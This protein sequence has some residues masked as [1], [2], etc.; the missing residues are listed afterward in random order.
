[1]TFDNDGALPPFS[2]AKWPPWKTV[3]TTLKP[4]FYFGGVT[5]LVFPLRASLNALQHFCDLYL[6]ILPPEVGYFRAPF[7]YVLLLINDYGSMS[8]DVA[9][10]GWIAERE[11]AFFVPLQW[12]R[13]IN[14]RLVF[15]DYA[16]I[17]PFI[18]VDDD[19]AL[20][21]GRLV[22]GWPKSPAKSTPTAST[23]VGNPQGPICELTMTASLFPQFFTGQSPQTEV[24]LSVEHER[25][26]ANLRFPFNVQNPLNPWTIAANLANGMAGMSMDIVQL[27][28]GFG[29]VPMHQATSG[30]NYLSMFGAMAGSLF[31]LR[32]NF[33]LN[34]LNLKQFRLSE[35]PDC[36]AFQ[37]VTNA[38]IEIT[39]ITA[40]GRLGEELMMFGD[41]SGGYS[42][43]LYDWPMLPIVETLG[44]QVDERIPARVKGEAD[45]FVLKPVL[46]FWYQGDMQYKPG[47]NLAWRARSYT[48]NDDQ[49]NQF[50]GESPRDEAP[51]F[52]TTLAG[53]NETLVGPFHFSD[54]V[55]RALPLLAHRSRLNSFICEYLNTPMFGSKMRFALWADADSKPDV[56]PGPCKET[57]QP[58]N[59]ENPYAYV[60]L[61]AI[62]VGAV[63]SET[64]DIGDWTKF[65]VA[66]FVPV[67]LQYHDNGSWYTY[68]A[69]LLPVFTFMDSSTAAVSR[70][71]V[72][73]IPTTLAQFE[74][75]YAQRNTWMTSTGVYPDADRL[76]LRMETEVLPAVDEGQKSAS[77]TILE[78][79]SGKA[80]WSDSNASND[81]FWCETFK[82]ELERKCK[83]A[84]CKVDELNDGLALALDIM[85][86]QAP[87]SLF[88][89]K[90]FRDVAD[91]DLACYQS[92]VQ[93]DR[94]FPVTPTVQE[95]EDPLRLLIYEFPT[96]PIVSLLGL[97]HR[98]LE[99]DGSGILYEIR[100][101]RPFWFAANVDEK[102]GQPLV[103]RAPSQ[104]IPLTTIPTPAEFS[105]APLQ[106]G[107]EAA[108]MVDA[109]D[110]RKLDAAVNRWQMTTAKTPLVGADVQNVLNLFGP[111]LIIETLLSR[112][113]RSPN[114]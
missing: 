46:P 34:T 16:S 17:T 66:I 43:K 64:N 47:T 19:F 97:E 67:R 104:W 1:M 61:A 89:L 45:L 95:I 93:T 10:V 60:Y 96:L 86:Q 70:S 77:E 72:S 37:A 83:L 68:C 36:C 59:P 38:P 75:P 63:Q 90:Q 40:G 71:E 84:K 15:Y 51:P 101:V 69:G 110:P 8:V 57:E 9:N 6:N 113:W 109:G 76:L 88:T 33:T 39:S 102:L 87:I 29:V 35:S 111:E 73:G 103:Y 23:W 14:G 41:L 20:G 107:A 62:S 50:P 78:I 5:S 48:W 94:S 80:P 112:E 44:L 7:P 100:P 26:A 106:I 53:G 42:V 92:I 22:Y 49:G 85:C 18:Y 114:S 91:P 105:A 31:P 54:V 12:Y 55:V 3:S 11:V 21:L 27:L 28:R 81:Y 32:P 82:K 4:P 108:K 25:P 74:L 2:E 65:E 24:F 52:N 58:E 56:G 13:R 30:D 99:G 98:R 79:H